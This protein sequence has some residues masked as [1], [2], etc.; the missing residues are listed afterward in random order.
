MVDTESGC[1]SSACNSLLLVTRSKRRHYKRHR[2]V[3][4]KKEV[5]SQSSFERGGSN[6]ENFC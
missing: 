5:P 4:G 1:L 6:G 2:K 3:V